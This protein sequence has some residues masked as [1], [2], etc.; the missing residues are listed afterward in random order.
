MINSNA[1]NDKGIL[2]EQFVNHLAYSSFMRYW[3]YPSPKDENGDKKEICDLLVLFKSTAVIFCVKNYEFKGKY[4]RYLRKTIDKDIRQIY[5]AEKKLTNKQRTIFIKH[6]E[7][8]IE[9]IPIERI[10]N[11]YRVVIHLGDD[12]HFYPIADNR[13]SSKFISVFDKESFEKT[14]LEL[15]TLPDF[16]K[17]LEAREKL[18]IDKNVVCLPKDE[19]IPEEH[20]KQFYEYITQLRG[21]KVIISGSELDLLALYK[22]NES[23]FSLELEANADGMFIDINGEWRKYTSHNTYFK[24]REED[25]VNYFI[26][27]LVANELLKNGSV[28]LEIAKVLL[29]FNRF[30]RRFIS[31]SFLEFYHKHKMEE[32][33]FFAKRF[34]ELNEFGFIFLFYPSTLINNEEELNTFLVSTMDG[35]KIHNQYEKESY[36]VIAV[37]NSFKQFRFVYEPIC[38]HL[39]VSEEEKIMMLCGELGW[40]TNEKKFDHGIIKEFPD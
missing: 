2:G 24:K 17:Y 19:S 25:K 40:F 1:I 35:H 3:C 31:I 7:R 27:K 12:V 32:S 11:V 15:D 8:D 21:N 4:E 29:S 14:I 36:L 5:G 9:E 37:T 22:R 26:D 39:E 20:L 38:V 16:I 18:F 23:Q 34:V 33:F 6:P 30:E 10:Q 28:L 13:E